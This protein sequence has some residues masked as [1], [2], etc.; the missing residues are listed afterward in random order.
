[1]IAT[2][3]SDEKLAC[4]KKLG[5]DEV[6]NYATTSDWG[7]VVLD[8]TKGVGVDRVIEVGVGDTVEMALKRLS[9]ADESVWSAC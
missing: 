4:L 6:I 2:S 7:R 1:M 9:W 3:S 5:A 8:L